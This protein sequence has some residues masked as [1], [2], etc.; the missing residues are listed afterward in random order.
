MG[1]PE[2]ITIKF[3]ESLGYKSP[4]DRPIIGVLKYID[5]LDSEGKPS[6]NYRAFR[7]R[8]TGKGAMGA[9]LMKSFADL[10]STYPDA[11]DKDKEAL[12]NFFSA[13]V[14][15]GEKVLG[16]TVDTFKTLCEFADF[17]T[18]ITK[19]LVKSEGMPTVSKVSSESRG[20]VLNLNI[21]LQLPLTE[22]SK[23]YD[24]I[25]ASLRKNLLER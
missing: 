16:A 13:N 7:N 20:L 19:G 21:Q 4:N 14:T 5:F 3:L 6:A 10:F 8:D 1:I 9:C 18:P 25:F 2:K 15:G 12:R 23:I 24:K 17:K 11:Y 22:D